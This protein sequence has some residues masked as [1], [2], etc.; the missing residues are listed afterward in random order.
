MGAVSAVKGDGAHVTGSVDPADQ[1]T[2]YS[3]ETSTDGVNWTEFFASAEGPIAPG[4]GATNVSKDLTGLHG[5]TEYF[6]RLA[7]LNF[8]EFQEVVSAGPN[9]SFTTLAV[10][11]PSVI[12]TN[13]ATAVSYTTAEVSGEVERP[14]GAESALDVNCRF[15]Y[16]SDAQFLENEDNSQPGFAN[17]AQ[18]PCNVNP[19]TATGAAAVSAELTGLAVG[20]TYHLRLAA[21]NAGGTATKAAAH[22][23]ATLAVQAPVVTIDPVTTFTGTTAHFSGTI[24]PGGTDPV[25]NV[26]WRFVCHPGCPGPNGLS[27]GE[28]SGGEISA[29]NS[30]HTV[31]VDATGLE[32]NTAYTVELVATNAAGPAVKGPL[33][34]HTDAVAP[35]VET[36]PAFALGDGTEA[37]VGGKVN[38]KNSATTYWVEYGPTESYG[39]SAPLTKDAPAGSGGEAKV[40]TQTIAGL[41]P[42]T[43]YHVRLVAKNPTGESQGLDMTF[44][45]TPPPAPS[46]SCPNATL[47]SENNSTALP[48]CRAYEQVSPVDK[49][50]YDAGTSI[51]QFPYVAATEGSALAFE[52]FGGFSGAVGASTINSYLS[53]RGNSGWTTQA[54]SP[55]HAPAPSIDFPYFN[56]FTPDLKDVVVRA[57]QGSLLAPGATP[58]ADNLY[59]RDNDTGTYQTLNIGGAA[60]EISVVG[61]SVDLSHVVFS[62]AAA[63]NPGDPVGASN[64]YDWSNGQVQLVS[65]EP[66]SDSPMPEGAQGIAV[67]KDGSRVLFSRENQIYLRENDQNTVLVSA[68]SGGLTSKFFGA[69]ADLSTLYFTVEGTN[70]LYQYD[71]VTHTA[72][73]LLAAAEPGI[74]VGGFDAAVS[75]DGSYLYFRAKGPAVPGQGNPEQ[76]NLYLWHDGSISFVANLS[77]DLVDTSPIY[78]RY[79]LSSNARYLT[80]AAVERL[81][82][83]DNTDSIT[84]QPDSEVYRYDAVSKILT[85]ISCNPDGGAP[86]GPSS[87]PG[88]PVRPHNLTPGA[89]PDGNV[90]FDSSDALVPNDVNGKEDV[91]EWENGRAQLISSGTVGEPSFYA[92]G[93]ANGN[94]IYLATR[95][96]LVAA[97]QDQDVDVYDARVDGGFPKAAQ[98][99]LCEGAEACHGPASTAPAFTNPASGSLSTPAPLSASARRLKAALKACKQKPK[100]A[101]A[102]CRASA[103][104]RFTKAGRA[105]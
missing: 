64:I 10:A 53:R 63:L 58:E 2:Y 47:R 9:P 77:S 14:A 46:E 30:N 79:R 20:T 3:F 32:P 34:F 26:N 85:C 82:S 6:V 50:G 38:P 43:T 73:N 78:T 27:Q 11:A 62:V 68:V 33:S 18:A 39:Q 92:S 70:R 101:R 41:T 88:P 61:M 52:S 91:Y 54:L 35:S 96:Q 55:P 87:I 8:T 72:T 13:D 99:S 69:S 74:V 100:K 81:T 104:K 67:S 28:L 7:A 40:L 76:Y 89:S 57:T 1:E 103:R 102:K 95:Q 71:T 93:S 36:L 19:V 21:E 12:A 66:G 37:L 97:D 59:L 49:N 75:E 42:A 98:S 65:I 48:E 86:E 31:Q 5:A 56:L 4:S 45:S 94:D 80:F 105:N 60:P 16:L 23:F 17:A 90:V 29:D 24:D 51:D 25:F 83:Y 22:T 15:E 84:G 44:E